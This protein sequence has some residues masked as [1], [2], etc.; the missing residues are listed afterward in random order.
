[1]NEARKRAKSTGSFLSRHRSSGSIDG[2]IMDGSFPSCLDDHSANDGMQHPFVNHN[3]DQDLSID[4]PTPPPPPPPHSISNILLDG[5]NACT[6]PR[7]LDARRTNLSQYTFGKVKRTD[8]TS[9]PAFINNKGHY[10]RQFLSSNGRLP[11]AFNSGNTFRPTTDSSGSSSGVIGGG[12]GT[13]VNAK[14]LFHGIMKIKDGSNKAY[15]QGLHFPLRRAGS[16]P[17]TLPPP[18]PPPAAAAGGFG[19]PSYSL[20]HPHPPQQQLMDGSS[21]FKN[22]SNSETAENHFLNPNSRID[23]KPSLLV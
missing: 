11:S 3:C 15:N 6:L 7:K 10:P 18:P 9:N 22:T 23:S 19:P 14:K 4:T 17:D 5:G 13:G 20:Q 21:S 12:V 2:I 1:M 16:P 8:I